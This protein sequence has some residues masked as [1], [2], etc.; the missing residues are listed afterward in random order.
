MRS[1]ADATFREAGETV[2][3]NAA[4]DLV[5]RLR[6]IRAKAAADAP[7]SAC[8]AMGYAGETAVKAILS[9]TSHPPGTRTPS[10]PGE[11]PALITGNL[12]RSV[13]H[14][15][16][17]ETGAFTFTCLVG[18]VA[19]YAR[20]QE[21]GGVIHPGSSGYLANRVTGQFFVTPYSRRQYVRLPPRPYMRP[22]GRMLASS[23]LLAQAAL[24]GWNAVMNT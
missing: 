4:Q 21:Y 14:S 5:A 20:I 3:V 12:R 8:L 16:P 23:G 1:R 18:P 13:T 11:P 9:L 2:S 6:L 19:V 17:A 10:R 15:P 24:T 7:G 22:T